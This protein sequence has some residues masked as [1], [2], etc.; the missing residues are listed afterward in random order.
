MPPKKTLQ[1][2]SQPG[3]PHI[4]PEPTVSHMTAGERQLDVIKGRM[5]KWMVASENLEKAIEQGIRLLDTDKRQKAAAAIREQTDQ[6]VA[7]LERG[8]KVRFTF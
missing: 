2:V 4:A 5:N 3:A 7:V 8:Q 1:I 6:L